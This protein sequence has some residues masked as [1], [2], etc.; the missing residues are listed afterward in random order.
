MGGRLF[1]LDEAT[2]SVEKFH[3]D[4]ST[5][6]FTITT[7]QEVS[8]LMDLN[9]AERMNGVD[10]KAFQRKIASVPENIYWYWQTKW[11]NEGRSGAEIKELWMKFFNDSDH[12]DFKT[13]DGRV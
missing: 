13:I 1:S 7:T 2:K 12:K 8:G 11:R 5:G 9:H 6:N 3:Y 4:E 10:R